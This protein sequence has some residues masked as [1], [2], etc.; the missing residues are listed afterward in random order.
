MQPKDEETFRLS[1]ACCIL[2]SIS[3]IGILRKK[4]IGCFI[5]IISNV[6]PC[7]KKNQGRSIPNWMKGRGWEKVQFWSLSKNRLNAQLLSSKVICSM[8]LP[9]GSAGIHEPR[10][11][12][13]N[14]CNMGGWEQ[15]FK[16]SSNCRLE[17]FHFHKRHHADFSC[18]TA[19][20]IC[21]HYV[22]H[23]PERPL[24]TCHTIDISLP[25]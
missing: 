19:N 4:W 11:L 13:L 25:N 22:S 15:H 9:S 8:A 24:S 1:D 12:P 17:W 21:L 6:V 3:V 14:H 18:P 10:E 7:Y 20:R 23:V 16:Y 5:V 2:L